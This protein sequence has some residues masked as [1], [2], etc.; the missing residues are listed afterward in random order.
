[1]NTA[2]VVLQWNN[3]DL[4]RECLEAVL[5]LDPGPELVVLCDNASGD[6]AAE[7]ALAFARERFGAKNVAE[8]SPSAVES[9]PA[10]RF[11]LV[12]NPANLGFAAGNNPGLRLA[13]ARGCGFAW[14]LNN[15]AAPEPGALGALMA[16]AA[17]RPRAGVLGSSVVHA[18]RPDTLQCA[19]GC[20][21]NPLTTV[22]RPARGGRPLAEALAGPEPRLDYVYGASL[23]V[24]AEVLRQVGLLCEEFFLFYEEL[25]LCC[26]A[27]KAGWD[28]AWCRQSVVRHWGGATVGVAPGRPGE[29]ADPE[30]A[31][32][33]AYHET[34]STLLY[35][36][37]HHPW[38]L[39]AVLPLRLFG[40]TY[41]SV[42]HRDFFLLSPLVA[43]CRDA[44][45]KS[46]LLR[47][48]NK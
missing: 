29:A 3:W 22:F 23:F 7:E 32:L 34:L 21:Y 2:V 11:A 39:P 35:T 14:L 10:C 18:D 17:A 33:A 9:A 19:G 43:A 42:L 27:T 8:L 47:I 26:R 38:L 16:C 28:L 4:T 36:R 48:W 30:R 20:A 13:L 5:G 46:Y 37:R 24:R 40:K 6:G 45:A 12:R 15:D 25:D 31:A 44:L 41:T 1:M